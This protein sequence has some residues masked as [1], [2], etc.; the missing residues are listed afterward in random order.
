M[1]IF[2]R[3]NFLIQIPECEFLN[4]QQLHGRVCSAQPVPGVAE[5]DQY[6]GNILTQV[7]V[8]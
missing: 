3:K 8:F 7:V 2:F 6:Q 4:L 1:L 5:T